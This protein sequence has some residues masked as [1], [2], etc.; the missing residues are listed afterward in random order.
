[1]LDYHPKRSS[2]KA[3][4]SSQSSPHEKL[5]TLPIPTFSATDPDLDP[6]WTLEADVVI[7]GSGA[8]G[9]IMA[10]ELGPLWQR[11]V[12]CM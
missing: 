11:C 5:P 1:V 9:G 6:T 2:A 12:D 8:G 3:L 10:H 4:S 7:V